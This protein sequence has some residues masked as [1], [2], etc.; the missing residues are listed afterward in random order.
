M[1]KILE[2]KAFSLVKKSGKLIEW[3]EV[4]VLSFGMFALASL[5]IVNVIARTFFKSIYFVPEI[6]EFLVIAITFAGVS[7]AVRKARHI[8]M[9][10]IFDAMNPKIQKVMIIIICAVSAFVM[11]LMALYAYQYVEVIMNTNQRTPALR[12]PYWI[13]LVMVPIGFFSAG[14]QYIRTIIKNIKEPDVWLSP[15]QQGEYEVEE[16]QNL[17]DKN[18]ELADELLFN[19]EHAIEGQDKE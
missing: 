5:L 13:F 3:F 1:E 7:Y 4:G 2:S 6:S 16:L 15:E 8:R 9:G 14:L 19:E 12:L 10:A 17:A 11:F 18:K